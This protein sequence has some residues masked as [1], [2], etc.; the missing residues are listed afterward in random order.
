MNFGVQGQVGEAKQA[1]ENCVVWLLAATT[2][3]SPS[4]G[5]RGRRL[6]VVKGK[7]K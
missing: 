3:L 2:E 1:I 4:R 7:L 5:P 6:P